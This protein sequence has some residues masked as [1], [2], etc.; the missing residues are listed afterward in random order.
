V[1]IIMPWWLDRVLFRLFGVRRPHVLC[2]FVN[3]RCRTNHRLK[4]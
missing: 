3:G 2:Q 1:I 4:F